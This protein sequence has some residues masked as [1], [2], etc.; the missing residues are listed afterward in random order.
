[1]MAFLW[2]PVS[3][4][5]WKDEIHQRSRNI[6]DILYLMQCSW[7]PLNVKE[8][9]LKYLLHHKLKYMFWSYN[10]QN[11]Y[12]DLSTKNV[13]KHNEIHFFKAQNPILSSEFINTKQSYS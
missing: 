12:L 8:P 11:L 9:Y 3:N 2:T 7:L 10:N 1:M 4:K 5:Y 13:E 6:N